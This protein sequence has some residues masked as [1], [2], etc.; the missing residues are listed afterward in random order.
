[1]QAAAAINAAA[2]LRV[3]VMLLSADGAAAYAGPS[4][5]AHLIDDAHTRFPEVTVVGVLDCG[6]QPGLAM[7][8]LRDGFS[9]V[10]FDGPTFDKIANIAAQL[11]AQALQ[12]RPKCLTLDNLRQDSAILCSAC[13]EWL[14]R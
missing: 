11:D 5:F 4:W 8:A 3:S 13:E 6:D 2:A 10:R 12:H 14:Q 7:A 1:M 9:I